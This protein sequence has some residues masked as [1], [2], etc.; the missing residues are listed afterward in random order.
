[1]IV[2]NR[3]DLLSSLSLS[4]ISNNTPKTLRLTPLFHQQNSESTL[5]DTT[6]SRGRTSRADLQGLSTTD[7]IS[8]RNS[9]S[10]NLQVSPDV[11]AEVVKKYI[12]PMFE[13]D[14][15]NSKDSARSKTFGIPRTERSRQNSAFDGPVYAELK[16]SEKLNQEIKS[17]REELEHQIQCVKRAEQEKELIKNEFGHVKEALFRSEANYAA[18]NLELIEISKQLQ[19]VEQCHSVLKEQAQQYQKQNS[20]LDTKAIELGRQLH[21]EMAVNDKLKNIALQLH[22]GNSLLVMQS[23]IMGERLKGLFES[24]EFL[25]KAQSTEAKLAEEYTIFSAW[26]KEIANGYISLYSELRDVTINRDELFKDSVELAELKSELQGQRDK[27]YKSFKDRVSYLEQELSKTQEESVTIKQEFS[28]LEKK[29]ADISNEYNRM[30]QRLKQFKFQSELEEKFCKN[31]QKPYIESENFNWSCK[32]HK[33]KFSGDLYWCCGRAGK[34][35]PGCVSSKHI[36][37]DDEEIEIVNEISR[38]SNRCTSCRTLGHF[39]HE[40]PRDPNARTKYEPKDE[41]ER[42]L[43]VAKNKKKSH[44]LENDIQDRMMSLIKENMLEREATDYEITEESLENID[45]AGRSFKDLLKI[46]KDLPFDSYVN[47]VSLETEQLE[48]DKSLHRSL[49]TMKTFKR[50]SIDQ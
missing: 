23:E 6:V 39:A 45:Y 32:T 38:L 35:A 27:I 25:T 19:E 29:F 50:K 13:I 30:R 10:V 44:V 1:M 47:R 36:S 2:G 40:C 48:E 5:R 18:L 31:C 11:A 21:D 43:D 7:R 4:N 17:L 12:L 49:K 34:D 22:H 41:L 26:G 3:K 16:L 33:S 28:T 42:I 37:K 46:K 24:F 9:K 20:E 8:H 14:A 15:R